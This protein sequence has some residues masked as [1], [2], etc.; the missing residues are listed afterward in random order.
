MRKKITAILPLYLASMIMLAFAVIPHHHHSEYICFNTTHCEEGI[1]EEEEH[2]HDAGE[3]GCVKYLFQTEITK[4]LSLAHSD[5]C[6]G[7]HCHHFIFSSFTLAA[8]MDIL[9]LEIH[10]DVLPDNAYHEKLHSVL[11]TTDRAGRAPPFNM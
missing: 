5:N 2:D 4:S 7:G 8:I 11:Y 9:S 3:T 10:Q 6:Q 1:P